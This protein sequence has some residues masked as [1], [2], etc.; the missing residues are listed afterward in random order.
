[1]DFEGE[2]RKVC[3]EIADML[4]TK[5]KC[6]GNSALEPVRCFSKADAVEQLKVRLDDK[7][8]RLMR[9]T[10]NQEDTEMDMMGYLVLLKIAKKQQMIEMM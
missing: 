3:N 8:S 1:M 7:I 5:N 4:V 9:G 6:Y 10:D 2:V